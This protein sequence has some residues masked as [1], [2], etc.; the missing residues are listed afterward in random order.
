V[1]ET[2]GT[3]TLD[4]TS[5]PRAEGNFF[6]TVPYEEPPSPERDSLAFEAAIPV[7]D[8]FLVIDTSHS[9]GGYINNVRRNIRDF[10][11]I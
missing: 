2:L 9:M 5:H 1:E 10:G 6:F 4:N 8:V 3:D 11:L 7:A